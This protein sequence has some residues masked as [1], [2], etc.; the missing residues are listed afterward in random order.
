MMSRTL[1]PT[2]QSQPHA[3]YGTAR[4]KRSRPKP[5]SPSTMSAGKPPSRRRTRRQ[6]R[7]GQEQGCGGG[8]Q[9]EEKRIAN[10][11]TE[12]GRG[13]SKASRGSRFS[14]YASN[15]PQ[16]RASCFSSSLPVGTDGKPG[17][18]T[19]ARQRWKPPDRLLAL[20]ALAADH[21]RQSP[22]GRSPAPPTTHPRL[23]SHRLS[24]LV[25]PRT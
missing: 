19:G 4:A 21:A 8:R 10:S 3:M 11:P 7:R 24:V 17:S 12:S 9:A 5:G 18:P 14:Q 2:P 6:P 22:T 16:A 13:C 1:I 25:L 23:R 15:L 20:S